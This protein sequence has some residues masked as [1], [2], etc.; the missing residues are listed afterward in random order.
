MSAIHISTK[1]AQRPLPTAIK[2]T[3]RLSWNDEIASFVSTTHLASRQTKLPHVRDV[4]VAGPCHEV[5]FWW[6]QGGRV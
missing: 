3:S 1:W 4:V 2:A 5:P 6:G